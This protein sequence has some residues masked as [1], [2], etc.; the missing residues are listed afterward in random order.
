M[1]HSPERM[2]SARVPPKDVFLSFSSSYLSCVR[3]FF[4]RDLQVS[5]A[6]S[7]AYSSARS[8]IV[9]C[10]LAGFEPLGEKDRS[11]CGI[12]ATRRSM[13]SLWAMVRKRERTYILRYSLPRQPRSRV[14]DRNGGLDEEGG[15]VIMNRW[16]SLVLSRART[17]QK[18]RE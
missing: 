4:S 16:H 6:W 12:S 1:S 18:R 8:L 2:Q 3:C 7:L 9:G 11:V 14:E 5:D 13:L 10:G 15:M 17:T